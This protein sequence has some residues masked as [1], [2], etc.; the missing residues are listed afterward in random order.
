MKRI[1]IA[2]GGT[3]GWL[4]AAYLASKLGSYNDEK[5]HI[6]LIES[7]DIS[8]IGVGEATTPS[9]R[10]T[11]ADIGF[12]E[13]D[14]MRLCDA[15]FKHG[16]LFKNWTEATN[17]HDQY[18]HPFERPL[19]AGTDGLENYWLRGFDVQ[20]RP[21]HDAV[22]I[23]HQIAQ[24]GLAPKTINDRPYDAPL[25]YAYHLDAGKLADALKLAALSRGVEHVLETIVKVNLD[26][27]Q[28][29]RS[30][31][32]H[33]NEELSADLFI[34]C[35]GFGSVLIKALESDEQ[36]FVDCNDI[37]FCDSAVTVQIPYQSNEKIK[38]YTT[39]T[40]VKHGWI[41]DIGLTGRK[42]VG[43]VYS[44]NHSNDDEAEA[45]LKAYI[46]HIEPNRPLRHLRFRVG[47]RQKQWINNC[48]AVG[49]SS[50][51]LEPLESTGIHLVEQ[52]IWSLAS[53]IPRY[54]SG[55]ECSATFNVLMT[56]HY[57]HAINFVKYHYI[58]SKRTDSAF[59]LDNVNSNSWTPW[60]RQKHAI[61][62]HSPPDI[63]DLQNLH[64]IFDH[65]SY[66][67]VYFGMGSRPTMGDISQRRSA[68][69]SRIFERVSDG[70][71]NANARLPSHEQLL[72]FIHKDKFDVANFEL[73]L[74]VNS[75][76]S[77]SIR[78]IPNNYKASL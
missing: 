45:V 35:S 13:F 3:S 64:T 29:I 6:T 75:K 31:T 20:N 60:L 38:P 27:T 54:F 11:L 59:W 55:G 49:L 14:F 28:H 74:S 71:N 8:T 51:F 21:F 22:S 26:E 58:L 68:F 69:A 24:L 5:L 46:G 41:W 17:Q 1:V 10:A 52:A 37:L 2:G 42:G 76:H 43:Y 30:L 23:Q 70:L 77:T 62:Q 47:Y 19:R 56:E 66:Q 9:I 34:D 18:F 32:L 67:Y 61:W 57:S 78:N 39:S 63:Y 40:A 53:L 65:S 7:S 15:S 4:T 50:G 72:G 36:N 33:N 25:P 16:I 44:S 12:D 48:I 73:G